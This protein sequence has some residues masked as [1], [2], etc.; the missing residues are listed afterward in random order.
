[1]IGEVHKVHVRAP[2]PFFFVPCVCVV[3]SLRCL[4]SPSPLV[5]SPALNKL[6]E[7]SHVHRQHA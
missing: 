1:M 4:V 3:M 7:Y 6:I 5:L 2:V